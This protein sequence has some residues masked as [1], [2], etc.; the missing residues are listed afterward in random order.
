MSFGSQLDR[1]LDESA[2]KVKVGETL[3]LRGSELD[4]VFSIVTPTARRTS[5]YGPEG[6]RGPDR[7]FTGV[8]VG[9]TYLIGEIG[10][11]FRNGPSD[12]RTPVYTR[13]YMPEARLGAFAG[14]S[15]IGVLA[16][17]VAKLANG[18]HDL[19]PVRSHHDF[20]VAGA[21]QVEAPPFFRDARTASSFGR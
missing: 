19:T 11:D 8:Q 14:F 9:P 18:P 13:L 21:R 1:R 5:H 15:K 10:V 3:G 20:L 7:Y 6:F 16:E 12:T 4:D 17:E 2:L